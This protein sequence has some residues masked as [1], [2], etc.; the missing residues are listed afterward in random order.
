MSDRGRAEKEIEGESKYK[1]RQK[2]I[3]STIDLVIFM[4]SGD[5]NLPPTRDEETLGKEER[6]ETQEE[7]GK[8][9][10]GGGVRCGCWARRNSA[11]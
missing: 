1:R 2:G 11:T 3:V 4:L 10:G 7:E 8:S 9:G 5:V 6:E